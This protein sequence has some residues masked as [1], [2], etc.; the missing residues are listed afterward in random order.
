MKRINSYWMECETCGRMWITHKNEDIDEC[1]CQR[2]ERLN[3]EDHSVGGD[4]VIS[5]S[6]NS[7]ET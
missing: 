6:L 1:I 7:M 3:P 4:K 2:F 5:D